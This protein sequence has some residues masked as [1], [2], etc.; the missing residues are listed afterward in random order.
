LIRPHDNQTACLPIN[1]A[2]RKDILAAFDVGT[3][4]LLIIAKPV[5][6]LL[7]QEKRGHGANGELA[8]ALLE[9]R[10]DIDH[11][12]DVGAVRRV[13]PDRRLR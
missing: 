13:F 9:D 4:H 12:V 7:G 5:A 11:A 8:M 6:T 10:P 3:E 1:A 2:H